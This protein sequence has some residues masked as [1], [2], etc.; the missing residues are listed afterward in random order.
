MEDLKV[1]KEDVMTVLSDAGFSSVGEKSRD[2]L[3]SV[4]TAFI[5]G[6]VAFLNKVK[7]RV[8]AELESE[9]TEFVEREKKSRDSIDEREANLIQREKALERVKKF[10]TVVEGSY[11]SFVSDISL[12]TQQRPDPRAVKKVLMLNPIEGK[13]NVPQ[14][15]VCD[16]C[17]TAD[18]VWASSEMK[19]GKWCLVNLCDK[20][21]GEKNA[22]K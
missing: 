1:T 6:K 2:R 7:A 3:L 20:C 17:G 14:K 10:L 16:K 18:N 19:D 15:Q 8:F 13:L 21:K 4:L 12:V 22:E 5:E 9:V 11:N